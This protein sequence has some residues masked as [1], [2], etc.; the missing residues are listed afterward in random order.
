MQTIERLWLVNRLIALD[1]NVLHQIEKPTHKEKKKGAA[2]L[3][4]PL[5]QLCVNKQV[6]FEHIHGGIQ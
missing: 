3:D 1:H 6:L 5:Y 2:Q 4:S